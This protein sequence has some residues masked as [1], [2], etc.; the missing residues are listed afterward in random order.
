MLAALVDL[1]FALGVE[2]IAEGIETHAQREFLLRAGCRVGQG[3]LFGEP[4]PAP[5]V[6][7]FLSRSR[8]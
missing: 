7:A 3:F 4:T 1:S 6:E 5:E 8:A 2:P